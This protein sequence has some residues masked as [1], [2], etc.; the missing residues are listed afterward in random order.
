MPKN[1]RSPRIARRK[2]TASPVLP[3]KKAPK[4]RRIDDQEL[5]AFAANKKAIYLLVPSL[6]LIAAVAAIFVFKPKLPGPL[7]A[8]LNRQSAGQGNPQ[9]NN[10][11]QSTQ[12]A[13][14]V[15]VYE[16]QKGIELKNFSPRYSVFENAD[17]GY[18]FAYPVGFGVTP[19]D[20]N[21]EI[22]PNTGSGKILVIV[23]SNS[24]KAEVSGASGKDL[25]V[26]NTAADFIRG[27][28][29]FKAAKSYSQS[30]LGKRFGD[31]NQG[32]GAY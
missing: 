11:P 9:G 7:A 19:V 20:N 3:E 24:F 5:S 29:Q 31:A 12:E 16:K 23:S 4:I 10:P 26:L 13:K 32:T 17:L 6:L 1:P 27:T 14:L 2:L 28:F 25:D 18:R 22:K 30:E 21:A 8:I 15:E